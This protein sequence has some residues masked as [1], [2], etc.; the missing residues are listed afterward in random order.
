MIDNIVTRNPV[1]MRWQKQNKES[2]GEKKVQQV[3]G[4]N[5]VSGALRSL[6]T[7]YPRR[8][9]ELSKSSVDTNPKSERMKIKRKTFFIVKGCYALLLRLV[10]SGGSQV[11]WECSVFA[12]CLNNDSMYSNLSSSVL[13][14]DAHYTRFNK[15]SIVGWIR[16][17]E[18]VVSCLK[19]YLK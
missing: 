4:G 18:L 3:F 11:G 5:L 1:K 19:L 17:P 10:T 16:P 9:S 12:Q 6:L 7:V 8:F 14:L 2:E 15:F 13:L